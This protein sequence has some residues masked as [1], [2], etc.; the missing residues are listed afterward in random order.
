MLEKVPVPTQPEASSLQAISVPP[1]PPVKTA[2]AVSMAEPAVLMFSVPVAVVVTVYQRS[3]PPAQLEVP[4][5]V[6]ELLGPVPNEPLTV[7]LRAKVAA[8][9]QLSF[10]G[11]PPIAIFNSYWVV[12]PPGNWPPKTAFG[13]WTSMPTPPTTSTWYQV[14]AVTVEVTVWMPLAQRVTNRGVLAI[15]VA[16]QRPPAANED[17]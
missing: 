14:P 7:V 13:V 10:A 2:M 12:R 5:C 9:A 15:A 3:L 6:A 17:S 11:G 16:G 8:L 4:S 1:Q